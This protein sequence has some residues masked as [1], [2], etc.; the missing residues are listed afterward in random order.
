MEA[1]LQAFVNFKQNDWARLL[2]MAEFAFNN[3]KNASTGHMP[4]ELNCNYHPWILYKEEVDPHFKSKSADKLLAELREL[5]I[6]CQKNLHH[7]QKLQKGPTIKALSLETMPLVTK[8]GWIAN[9]SRSNIT[10][11][12]RQS[13]LNCCK[14]YILLGSKP[15]S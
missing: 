1:Y 5:M 11:S 14:L 4:F 7:A 10:R 2:S 8:Y 13:S 15:I 9:I 12:W 6:F 3:A